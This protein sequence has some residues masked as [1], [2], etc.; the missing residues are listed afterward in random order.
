MIASLENG[1]RRLTVD[2]SHD[3]ANLSGVSGTSEVRV[4]LF[5][6]MLVQRYKAV[7]NIVA[8]SGIVRTT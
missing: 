6:L 1:K 8:S 5:G 2:S 3:K 7:E 4:D